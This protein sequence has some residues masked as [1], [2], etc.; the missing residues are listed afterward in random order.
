[1]HCGLNFF[2]T[3][4][5]NKKEKN[6]LPQLMITVWG[7]HLKRFFVYWTLFSSMS[8]LN[9][10]KR[11]FLPP[12]KHQILSALPNDLGVFHWKDS[13]S[14]VLFI[15]AKRVSRVFPTLLTETT[16]DDRLRWCLA[17]HTRMTVLWNFAEKMLVQELWNFAEK[18]LVSCTLFSSLTFSHQSE[19]QKGSDL[20]GASA[21][22][23]GWV[24][25]FDATIGFHLDGYEM[26]Q[27]A[28]S[29]RNTHSEGYL[30]P[31]GRGES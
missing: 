30:N 18:M 24:L 5:N 21:S 22:T 11:A 16:K 19:R 8:V 26:L 7:F 2:T 6:G 14:Q 27:V 29:N 9:N 20:G 13:S 15:L 31:P 3:L 1:M 25:V 4:N 23:L 17:F 10:S 28:D 12:K